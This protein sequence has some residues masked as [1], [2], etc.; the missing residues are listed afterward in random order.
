VRT[1]QGRTARAAV[2]GGDAALFETLGIPIVRGRWID[3]SETRGV[4]VVSEALATMLWPGQDP[5]GARLTIARGRETSSAVVVGVA[6][7]AIDGAGLAA[8]GLLVPDA[9]VPIDR[10]EREV[11]LLARTES[12]PKLLLKGIRDAV[13]P[14][15]AGRPPRVHVIADSASFVH[16]DSLFVVKLLGGFGLIAM[17]LAASGIFGVISQSVAQRTTEF[18][19]RMAMGASAGQVLRMVLA[20]EAKLIGFATV[21]G[22]VATVLVTRSA[23]AEMLAITAADPRMWAGVAVLCGGLAAI[24][25]ALATYRIL[26]LDP[27]VVL[28]RS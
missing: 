12:N 22:V 21:T 9:Y 15:S 26:R 14:S 6:R 19:M 24:A 23:F 17:L 4:A 10:S 13:R 5:L 20:R 11:L 1:D 28:R 7:N 25:V 16:P 27:W 3:H 2:T 18:G 8:H